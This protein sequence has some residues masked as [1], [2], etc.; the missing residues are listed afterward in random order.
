[1]PIFTQRLTV[2][3]QLWPAAGW[4]SVGE[5]QLKASTDMGVKKPNKVCLGWQA[6][7]TQQPS[8]ACSKSSCKRPVCA[9]GGLCTGARATQ[10]PTTSEKVT[11]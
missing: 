5:Q 4:D 11:Q 10:P 6:S 2:V 9:Q 3:W 7:A 8:A 1:M